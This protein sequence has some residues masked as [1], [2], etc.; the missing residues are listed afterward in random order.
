[1]IRSGLTASLSLC[2]AGCLLDVADDDID[3]GPFLSG[4]CEPTGP[5]I[6]LQP[7]PADA[8]ALGP[9]GLLTSDDAWLLV[10][11]L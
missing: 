10:A 11:E 3:T 5:G 7:L 4:V 1:M 8:G 2:L 9:T 6:A